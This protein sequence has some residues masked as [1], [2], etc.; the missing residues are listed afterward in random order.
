[1]VICKNLFSW[2]E[3]KEMGRQVLTGL[4]PLSLKRCSSLPDYCNI[5]QEDVWNSMPAEKTLQSE[6][7]VGIKR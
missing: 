4:A 1:M 5:T 7:Q 6:M 3:D 2:M